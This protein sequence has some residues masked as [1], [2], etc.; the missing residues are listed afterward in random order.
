MLKWGLWR[1]G[2]T[3]EE[4]FC[5]SEAAQKD[6]KMVAAH[7]RDDARNVIPAAIELI[8]V[9]EAFGVP[10]QFSHIGSMGAYGQ[11]EQLLS[12]FDYYKTRGVN[13]GAD[14]YPYN[15]FSTGL[16][17][18]TYDE[19]FLERYGIDYGSIEI[20]RGEYRGQRLTEDLFFKL[21]ET[22]PEL[23]T[24]AYVM[25]EE[26]VDMAIIH[27]DVCIAS[28][29][30]LRNSQGHPRASG[31]FPR[32]IK[33]YVKEK[34][35]LNLYQAIEK[36]TYLPAKRTGIKKGSLGVNDDADIVIF[37]YEQIEDKSTFK[38]PALP[39][40]GLKYVIIGGKIAV[41]DNKMMD[42][43]LGRSTRK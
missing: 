35:F 25:N 14:C 22:H 27:P 26:E 33:K 7:I 4:L 16:G 34:K 11:M 18:T 38:Q 43:K 3:K 17:E 9:G 10:I 21:R 19:G 23:S 24:I 41:K 32:F 1:K 15:A 5:I 28:D 2:I 6:H 37:N 36:M 30:A 29:G 31:T 13:I 8:E 40:K 42:N 39:P 12:L 20:S